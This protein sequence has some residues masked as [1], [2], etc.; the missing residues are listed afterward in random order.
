MTVKNPRNRSL[1]E[2][3]ECRRLLSSIVK[4]TYGFNTI[5]HDLAFEFNAN[6]SGPGVLDA[7]DLVLNNATRDNFVSGAVLSFTNGTGDPVIPNAV[8]HFKF[9]A[10]QG[11]HTTQLGVLKD[12][13]YRASFTQDDVPTLNGPEKKDFNFIAGDTDGNGVIDFDDYSRIDQGFNS[14]FSGYT[15]GDFDYNAVVDFDDYSLIDQAFNTHWQPPPPGPG[16]VSVFATSWDTIHL[17]WVDNVSG[18]TGWRVQRSDD[19][20]TFSIVED[21]PANS[22]NWDDG[23]PLEAALID[24]KRYWYRVRSLAAEGSIANGAYTPKAWSVTTLKNASNLTATAASA[25]AIN[26][27]WTNNSQTATQFYIDRA[28][29][30]KFANYTRT[31]VT[32]TAAPGAVQQHQDASGL[33]PG[34]QY[35]YRVIAKNGLTESAPSNLANATTPSAALTAANISTGQVNLDWPSSTLPNVIAYNVYRGTAS[36][37]TPSLDNV[38]G[39]EVKES[40][41]EDVD[42]AAASTFYYSVRA[43]KLDNTESSIATDVQ[44]NTLVAD[45]VAPAAPTNLTAIAYNDTEIELNWTDSST[46]EARFQV[47]R[48]VDGASNWEI[49]ALADASA[50]SYTVRDLP[51]ESTYFFRV[52][53]KNTSATSPATQPAP[54]TTRAHDEFDNHIVIVGGH[55]Q[56]QEW[57]N[58]GNG[59]GGIAKKLRENPQHDFA[60]HLY[61]EAEKGANALI[62]WDGTGKAFDLLN[63]AFDRGV[64]KFAIMGY[65]HGG[66]ITYNMAQRIERPLGSIRI[67]AF[68]GYI[69]AIKRTAQEPGTANEETRLPKDTQWHTNYFQRDGV[70]QSS[71]TVGANESTQVNETDG[72]NPERIKHTTIDKQPSIHNFIA[73]RCATKIIETPV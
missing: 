5:Q 27:S 31:T 4:F 28:T 70:P 6:M 17:D 22:V 14:G 36:G 1:V 13:Y 10:S 64:K 66:G 15:N 59:V 8:A 7:S 32:A 49:V 18:E 55:S 42:V 40:F 29:G 46:N 35:Y 3:L 65:S 71:H 43:V 52:K 38:V 63:A 44:V 2:T 67:L 61:S 25:S 60:V 68:T 51:Q 23:P 9:P 41:F 73:S 30:I 39:W 48:S 62:E 24:G 69:D 19:G 12:G 54:A 72:P 20:T 57:L 56:K 45:A 50:E 34:T 16:V 37:F 53:A 47:E 21:R 26:L 11:D 58:Q 33:S